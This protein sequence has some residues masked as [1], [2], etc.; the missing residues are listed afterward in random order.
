METTLTFVEKNNYYTWTK[1]QRFVS[2]IKIFQPRVNNSM[3]LEDGL[4]LSDEITDD[5]AIT[6]I[7]DIPPSPSSPRHQNTNIQ[8]DQEYMRLWQ[9]LFY[10]ADWDNQSFITKEKIDILKFS[11]E[12]MKDLDSGRKSRIAKQLDRIKKNKKFV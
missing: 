1:Q 11:L 5:D 9:K 7:A 4:V 12:K 6:P 2:N 8:P 10:H 3:D